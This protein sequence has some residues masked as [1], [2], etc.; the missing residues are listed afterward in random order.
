M[1]HRSADTLALASANAHARDARIR[2]V[3]DGHVYY[4]DDKPLTLS[5]TGLIHNA[6][7]DHFHP[8][9]A[10]ASMKRSKKWPSAK[11]SDAGEDGTL[12]PWSDARI[13]ESWRTN[14]ELAS[15]LGTD[16]HGRIERFLNGMEVAFADET[17]PN[18]REFGYFMAW[19]QT[20]LTAGYLP[21]RTEWVIY[22]E[23]AQLA[24]S[25]D[26]V[27]KNTITGKYAI[28][29]WKRCKTNDA[30]FTN[31]FRKKFLPPLGHIDDHKRNKWSLQVNVYREI[32][33]QHYGLEIE[34][35]AMVVCHCENNAAEV[36]LFQRNDAGKLLLQKRRTDIAKPGQRVNMYNP[37][38]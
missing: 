12:H 35:M 36:H 6:S 38:V 15:A 25:I 16:L 30:G 21:Y 13:L 28:V 7:G 33:E 24:G 18:K 11:Y 14:G 32:L 23:D 10:L 31:S 8:Q 22:D 1:E 19:W 5:V 4:L 34:S 20:Q 17:V 2:F 29:D 9:T 26:C 27:L 37:F 3:E